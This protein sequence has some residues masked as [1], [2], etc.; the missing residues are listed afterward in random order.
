MSEPK[1]QALGAMRLR[2]ALALAAL[3]LGLGLVR[4]EEGRAAPA[5]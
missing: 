5:P 4:P 2:R 3:A 1:I